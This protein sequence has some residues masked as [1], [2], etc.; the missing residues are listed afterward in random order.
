M[1]HLACFVPLVNPLTCDDG[2][3]GERRGRATCY[4]FL[5]ERGRGHMVFKVGETVVYPHRGAAL[6]EAMETP[7]IKGEERKPLALKA[8][9]GDPPVL[10][11]AENAEVVGV[12][13]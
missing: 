1:I 3:T 9:Q 6:R 11:P 12:R 13:D 7:T 8:P 10:V 5:S 4:S 2:R